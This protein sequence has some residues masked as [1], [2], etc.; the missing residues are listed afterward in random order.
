MQELQII[1]EKRGLEKGLAMKV[2]EQHSTND[3]L[4]AHMRDELWIDQTSLSRPIQAAW[5]SATSV[6]LF[7]AILIAVLLIKVR[8]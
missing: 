3:R 6:A 1:Y 5:I 2:A 4:G 7:A 8:Q